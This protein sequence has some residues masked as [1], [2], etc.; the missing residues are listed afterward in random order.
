MARQPLI[1]PPKPPPPT[2]ALRVVHVTPTLGRTGG[3]VASYVRDLADHSHRQDIE[4]FVVTLRQRGDDAASTLP[5][6][7]S[8]YTASRLGPAALGYSR[9]MRRYLHAELPEVDVVHSH[10]IRMYP[11][12]EARLLAESRELPLIIS[13][14]GQFDP[15]I[16]KHQRIR[17]AVLHWLY[18]TQNLRRANCLL[19]TCTQ[20]AT[21]IRAAGLRNPIA[22]VPVGIDMRPRRLTAD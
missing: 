3:G 22:I 5:E 10:G 1:R 18:E 14:H 7:I 2:P 21:H 11:S 15:W 6:G 8:Q 12:Y 20:E 17:K 13:P 9:D 4:P 19:A 16:S